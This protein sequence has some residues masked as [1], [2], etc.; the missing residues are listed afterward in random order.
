MS[1]ARNKELRSRIDS[2]SSLSSEDSPA[3]SLSPH[4][5]PTKATHRHVSRE[6]STT[7]RHNSH[8]RHKH[9]H[10]DH[11]GHIKSRSTAR[12]RS[13]HSRYRHSPKRR[14]PSRHYRDRY[15]HHD[16]RHRHKR[17]RHSS[18]SSGSGSYSSH[19][20]SSRRERKPLTQAVLSSPKDTLKSVSNTAQSASITLNKP[21]KNSEVA[22]SFVLTKPTNNGAATPSAPRLNP[23]EILDQI[24]KHQEAQAKAQAIAAA[25]AANLPKFYNPTSVNAVKLAEQQQ[26]RKLLWSKKDTSDGK[27]DVKTSLWAST[28]LIAG[29]GDTAAAAKF[30]KLMGIHET[31]QSSTSF[32]EFTTSVQ[33]DEDDALR[34]AEAQAELFR[35]LEQE[36]EMSRALTHTQRGVG[37]GFNAATLS[38]YTSYSAMQSE[39]EKNSNA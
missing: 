13:R 18:T 15:S 37:L 12:S 34:Q 4:V 29:K 3:R 16:Q 39:T 33:S 32:A 21:E 26:K 9:K 5:R 38:D 35:R 14:H 7:K 24:A 2:S 22:K 6:N 17:H 19:G 8:D 23:Q 11:C 36:Y 25:A 10:R 28:S 1:K 30:R 20:K 27:P 31:S